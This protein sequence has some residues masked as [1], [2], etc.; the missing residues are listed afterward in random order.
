MTP[1]P[2]DD[3]GDSGDQRTDT[4]ST[5]DRTSVDQ[6]DDAI[7][8]PTQTGT[9]GETTQPPATGEPSEAVSPSSGSQTHQTVPTETPASE[10]GVDSKWWYGVAAVP[11]YVLVGIVGG[12]FAVLL[13]LFGVAVD[14]GGGMGLATGLVVVLLTLGVIGY[15]LAG[16][17]LS[18]LFPVAIYLDA[19]E[20]AATDGAW[21]PDAVLYLIV[22][23]A[24]V[25]FSAFSLSA[26]VALY[27]LYR[28]NQA[29]GVP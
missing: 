26:V 21:E 11:I 16:L 19:K 28:R 15:A 25:V 5:D 9:P 18:I 10:T 22:A 23:A 4:I 1:P 27:Y 6:A 8:P 3:S 24:S 13:F 20:I 2:V 17:A 29:I 14:V 7:E 12:G